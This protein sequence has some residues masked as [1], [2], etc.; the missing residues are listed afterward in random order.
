MKIL[1]LSRAPFP[2]GTA[3]S[4]YI[5]NVCRT[6]AACG[7]TVKVIGCLRGNKTSFPPSGEFEKILYHNFDT[8]R[9]KKPVVYLFDKKW[10]YYAVHAI[11]RE[12]NPDI[13]FLYGGTKSVAERI[14]RFCKRHGIRYGAFN[15]EWFTPECFPKNADKR[16]V[17]DNTELIPFNAEHAD[18]AVLISTLLTDTFRKHG[19]LSVKIPNLIDPEDEKWAC[20]KERIEKIRRGI[21]SGKNDGIVKLAY[22]GVPGVGKDDLSAVIEALALLPEEMRK[23]TELHL[24]GVDEAFLQTYMGEKRTLLSECRDSIFPHG[25]AKQSDIPR[26]IGTCHY[27]VLIRKPSVRANAGFSTKMAE[28]FAAGVPVMANITGDIGTYLKDTVNGIIVKDSTPAACAEAIKRA[29]GLMTEN[30]KMCVAAYDTAEKK[31]DYRK[32]IGD[33]DAFLQKISGGFV[34]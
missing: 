18:A 23:K 13:V 33:M 1:I 12:K 26:L 3:P 32:Y 20:G 11:R 22:A 28:S 31:L 17:S 5:L 24:W 4:A 10:G 27:T 2:E 30:P 16:N 6:M 7:H 14:F 8:T 34:C 25:R 19:V 21:F 15:C 29:H 9:H